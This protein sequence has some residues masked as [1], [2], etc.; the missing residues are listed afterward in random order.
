MSSSLVRA[1][2]TRASALGLLLA[3][4]G[5]VPA[6]AGSRTTADVRPPVSRA[7]VSCVGATDALAWGAAEV[8]LSFG[9]GRLARG[10][11][12][13]LVPVDDVT[14]LDAGDRTSVERRQRTATV[15]VPADGRSLTPA[16][17]V[18]VRLG[19]EVLQ[20]IPVAG[21]CGVVD[22]APDRG[23]VLGAITSAAGTV[24]VAVEN[25]SSVRDEIGVTLFR[26][27]SNTGDSAFLLL[28]PGASGGVSFS[29]VA[30]GSYV[31]E[32]FG[33]TSFLSTRSG[34]F[35]VD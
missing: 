7:V 33:Y 27:G 20:R 29:G 26:V 34:P 14:G 16:T 10:A 2:L 23:P 28:E 17:T 25:G 6:H 35:A 22:P 24:R 1:R 32:A 21:G 15:L 13:L 12:Y 4:A 31:V 30:A 18:E 11:S 9:A 5:A 8:R 19:G 3:V